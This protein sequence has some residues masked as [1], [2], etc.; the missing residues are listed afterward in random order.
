LYHYKWAWVNLLVSSSTNAH[1]R[2]E[3][4]CWRTIK[5]LFHLKMQVL[6]LDVGLDIWEQKIYAP[7]Y[8]GLKNWALTEISDFW[9]ALTNYRRDGYCGVMLGS[10]AW[11]KARDMVPWL[12][13]RSTIVRPD[14]RWSYS[15]CTSCTRWRRSR[16]WEHPPG[17]FRLWVYL[18]FICL[19]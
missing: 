5:K 1:V 12:R 17:Q 18:S 2:E 16:L 15:T 7:R 9:I 8:F 14:W 6:I 4:S 10:C 19:R 3:I 11:K 13:C